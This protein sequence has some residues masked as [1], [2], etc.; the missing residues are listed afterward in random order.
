M[1]FW[2]AI[3]T[4]IISSYMIIIAEQNFVIYMGFHA[5][6]YTGSDSSPE[7]LTGVLLIMRCNEMNTFSDVISLDL[8]SLENIIVEQNNFCRKN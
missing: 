3:A 2:T 7:S 5:D 6:L 8:I 4:L 1:D